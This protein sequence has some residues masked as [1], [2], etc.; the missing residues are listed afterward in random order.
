MFDENVE[1]DMSEG[2]VPAAEGRS[3]DPKRFEKKFFRTWA[4]DI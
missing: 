1:W 4:G 2:P 3:M